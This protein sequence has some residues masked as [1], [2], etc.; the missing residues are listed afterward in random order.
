MSRF[1]TKHGPCAAGKA[2]TVPLHLCS[3]SFKWPFVCVLAVYQLNKNLICFS[4]RMWTANIGKWLLKDCFARVDINTP[5][6]ALQIVSERQKITSNLFLMCHAL[7]SNYDA[8]L[9]CEQW[10]RGEDSI[11]CFSRTLLICQNKMLFLS[12]F[13]PVSQSCKRWTAR[14]F[15]M[16]LEGS[17]FARCATASSP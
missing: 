12:V 11:G 14:G 2:S 7:D 5:A 15:G 17:L 13:L 16:F 4:I 10:R 1:N 6:T 8:G 9:L 3:A